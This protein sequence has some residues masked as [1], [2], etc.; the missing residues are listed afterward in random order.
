MRLEDRR[1]K[2]RKLKVSDAEF[3][4]KKAKD[5]NITKY[6]FVI[7][8]PFNLKEAKKFIREA[9]KNIQKKVSYEFGIELKKEKKLVGLINLLGINYK[10]KYADVGFWVAKEYWGKGISDE[11]VKLMLE[12]G[13]KKLKLKRIQARALHENIRAQKLVER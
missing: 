8:P 6:T 7:A 1:I 4:S 5:R 11:A 3:I 10:N 2:L 13:F 12:F 9:H